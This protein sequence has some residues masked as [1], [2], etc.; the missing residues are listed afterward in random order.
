MSLFLT[1]I[2][3]TNIPLFAADY[4]CGGNYDL[5]ESEIIESLSQKG[6]VVEE[7]YMRWYSNQSAYAANPSLHYGL[8][9][10]NRTKPFSSLKHDADA[11]AFS[12]F[13]NIERSDLLLNL[14]DIRPHMNYDEF[15]YQ[16]GNEGICPDL[17][18]RF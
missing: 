8:F 4:S 14:N 12:H 7:G 3:L 16:Y 9:V 17:S 11:D 13:K 6:Y 18:T 15:W 5:F 10:F 1:S 2:I